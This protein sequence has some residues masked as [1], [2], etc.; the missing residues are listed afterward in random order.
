VYERPRDS[1]AAV[2]LVEWEERFPWVVQGVTTRRAG[3][4]SADFDLRL[5]PESEGARDRWID[6]LAWSGLPAG[7]HARQVHEARVRRHEGAREAGLTVALPC[8][9]HFTETPGLLLTVSVADCVPVYVLDP[10]RRSVGMI[11][12]GWRG[13][14]AGILEEGLRGMIGSS[15]DVGTLHVHLGPSICGACYEVGGEVF[16]AL[17]LARPQGPTPIDLRAVLALRAVGAGVAPEA[18]TVSGHCTL[19]GPERRFFSHRGGDGGRQ[20]GFVG[21]R[22]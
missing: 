9:G 18:V 11:H 2:R 3:S 19:C 15:G 10:D 8:D 6:L 22:P 13:A 16:E 7:M 21:I 4:D 12:A 5:F 14:A 17:G 1:F 20:V